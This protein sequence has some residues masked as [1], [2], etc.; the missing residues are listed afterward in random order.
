MGRQGTGFEMNIYDRK[1]P[2]SSSLQHVDTEQARKLSKT[3]PPDNANLNL[4]FFITQVGSSQD[5]RSEP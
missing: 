4:Q 2:N 1:R 3:S 5:V